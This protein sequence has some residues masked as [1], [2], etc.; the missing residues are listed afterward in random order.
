MYEEEGRIVAV[1][2]DT[3]IV[4]PIVA[5]VTAGLYFHVAIDTA[6]RESA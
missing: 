5:W 6:A 3:Q 1:Q 4:L 2:P